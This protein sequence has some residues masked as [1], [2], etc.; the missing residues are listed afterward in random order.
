MV[1]RTAEEG[2]IYRPE[3][4]VEASPAM[5]RLPPAGQRNTREEMIE[6]ALRYPRRAARRQLR[7]SGCPLRA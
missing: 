6:M 7:H 4:V 3:A 2:M 1:V 5:N